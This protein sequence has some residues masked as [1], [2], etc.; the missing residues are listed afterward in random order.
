MRPVAR[1]VHPDVPGPAES[2]GISALCVEPWRSSR[3]PPQRNA[4]WK[5]RRHGV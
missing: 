1:P 5:R 3:R 4:H 2:G